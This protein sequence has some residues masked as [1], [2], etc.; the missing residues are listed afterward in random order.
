LVIGQEKRKKKEKQINEEKAKPKILEFV[1]S[2][3][4]GV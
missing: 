4:T 1:V 3:G 2:D